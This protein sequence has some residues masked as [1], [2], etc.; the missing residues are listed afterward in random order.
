MCGD[1]S[2]GKVQTLLQTLVPGPLSFLCV[3]LRL[4]C[5]DGTRAEELV[6]PGTGKLIHAG[7]M[8]DSSEFSVDCDR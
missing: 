7:V 3:G 8:D 1:P 4:E 6:C 2:I 5:L